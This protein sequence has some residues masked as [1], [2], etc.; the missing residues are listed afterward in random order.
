MFSAI[1][2]FFTIAKT[3][4]DFLNF[5]VFKFYLIELQYQKLG[6]LNT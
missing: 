2:L 1:A 4:L 6:Q 5:F 3:K